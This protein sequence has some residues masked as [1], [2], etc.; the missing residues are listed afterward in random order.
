MTLESLHS[1]LQHKDY[2]QERTKV[3]PEEV[4]K[5]CQIEIAYRDIA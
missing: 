1:K 5:F 2:P 3:I 4:R